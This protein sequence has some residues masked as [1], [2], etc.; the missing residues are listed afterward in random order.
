MSVLIA[1]ATSPVNMLVNFLFHDIIGAPSADEFK[2]E[3]QSRHLR[4]RIGMQVPIRRNSISAAKKNI[5]CAVVPEPWEDD[6]TRKEI[7]T[8]SSVFGRLLAKV[9]NVF[10]IPDTTT[11]SL[12]PSVMQSYA[13]TAM[14]LN[15]VFNSKG[16]ICKDERPRVLVKR[17]SDEYDAVESGGMARNREST[18][19]YFY[20]TLLR[21]SELLSGSAKAEFQGRWGLDP[22]HDALNP[23]SPSLFDA[24]NVVSLRSKR[25][26]L[27]GR[28]L[29]T[30]RRLVSE[31]MATASRHAEEKVKKL[32]TATDIHVGLEIM[33]LF[34]IDLL[35]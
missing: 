9:W 23:Q 8:G 30:R 28:K 7:E 31:A 21:Q 10:A 6:P 32:K 19:N 11:R 20:A 33:H 35:G 2:V 14:I 12:P 1:A 27:C 4:Q 17:T 26:S 13:S 15:D 22:G 29:H 3:L 25:N 16:L 24:D 18:I 5:A 34:I